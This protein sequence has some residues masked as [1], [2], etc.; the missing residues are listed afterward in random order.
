VEIANFLRQYDYILTGD[1]ALSIEWL[2]DEKE[3]FD[4]GRAKDVD[5]VIK[6]LIDSLCGPDRLLVDD[7][8]V[9]SVSVSWIDHP[10]DQIHIELRFPGDELWIR[11]GHIAF[12]HLYDRLY[13]PLDFGWPKEAE[14]AVLSVL[15]KG[16][17]LYQQAVEIHGYEGARYVRPIQRL[18]HRG[19]ITDFPIMSPWEY[20]RAEAPR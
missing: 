8:Q 1:V 17:K 5:N 7:H 9:H 11:K 6:P 4:S 15:N 18:F 13:I 19:H 12:I 20:V 10:S 3:R 2:G 14:K 16:R